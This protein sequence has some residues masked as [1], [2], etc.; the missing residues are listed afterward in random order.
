MYPCLACLCLPA[1]M[2]LAGAASFA[3]DGRVAAAGYAGSAGVVLA[4]AVVAGYESFIR[5]RKSGTAA[6]ATGV[7]SDGRAATV[8]PYSRVRFA[9]MVVLL[10]ALAVGAGFAAYD[11]AGPLAVA[12]VVVAAVT[13]A[14]YAG[15]RRSAL[16]VTPQGLEH[17]RSRGTRRVPW[18]DVTGIAATVE[19]AGPYW[20]EPVI[21]VFCRGEDVTVKGAALA[22]DPAV[23]LQLLRF[24][25]ARAEARGELATDAAR[26]RA[27]EGAF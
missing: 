17:R 14:G 12:V 7:D 10:I 24:Y 1:L 26:W 2:L 21:S 13:V 4:A 27:T 23:A 20:T 25:A 5:V 19:L 15:I 3:V 22:I 9:A 18:E 16:L 6:L 11:V 8:L